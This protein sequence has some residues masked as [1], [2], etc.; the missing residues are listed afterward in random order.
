MLIRTGV[1]NV[2]AAEEDRAD[3]VEGGPG[4]E[5]DDE[6]YDSGGSGVALTPPD[7]PSPLDAAAAAAAAGSSTKGKSQ[8]YF[9]NRRGSSVLSIPFDH[10]VSLTI[11]LVVTK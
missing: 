2:D 4:S 3:G 1:H 8:S 11:R 6:E 7:S 9:V 10:R 5:E